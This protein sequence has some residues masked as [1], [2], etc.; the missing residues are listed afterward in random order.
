[1][2]EHDVIEHFIVTEVCRDH[3]KKTDTYE[4][5]EHYYDRLMH[6]LIAPDIRGEPC[7]LRLMAVDGEGRRMTK[8]RYARVAMPVV[9]PRGEDEASF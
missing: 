9:S 7:E 1:M 3:E 2:Y 5:A 8:K 6:R 4:Q